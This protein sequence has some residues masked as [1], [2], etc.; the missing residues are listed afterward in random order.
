MEP[1]HNLGLLVESRWRD[2]NYVEEALPEIAVQALTD[3]ALHERVDPWDILRWLHETSELPF[4][5]D[6]ESTFGDLALTVFRSPRLS[7]R[8]GSRD[9]RRVGEQ[10]R[11]AAPLN[12]RS[13]ALLGG[14]ARDQEG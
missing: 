14:T 1:F 8:H 7:R 5:Q 4:Q 10:G 3:A 13:F 2:R 6:P 12:P 11:S 9:E